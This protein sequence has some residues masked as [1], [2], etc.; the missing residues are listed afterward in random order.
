MSPTA[1]MVIASGFDGLSSTVWALAISDDEPDAPHPTDTSAENN[2][3]E[4]F[5]L[6]RVDRAWA[7]DGV[8]HV[9]SWMQR[10]HTIM[11][12]ILASGKFSNALSD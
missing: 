9:S 2:K 12:T 11:P 4:I 6:I 10:K 5:S 7:N 8:A 3:A 1:A